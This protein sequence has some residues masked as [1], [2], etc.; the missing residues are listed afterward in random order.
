MARPDSS[1]STT[2]STA[3][4]AH[5]ALASS[6][7]A[8]ENTHGTRAAAGTIRR[9]SG[10][11]GRDQQP[12]GE[13]LVPPA[14]PAPRRARSAPG[15][16]RDRRHG[17]P[18]LGQP[19]RDALAGQR[20]DVAG[21]V[22]DEQH[23]PGDPAPGP[24][25][26]RPGAAHRVA[27]PARAARR[28]RGSPPSCSSN[29]RALPV[30]TATPTRSS[31]DRRHVR[32]AGRRPVDLD[33]VRPRRDA[34]VAAQAVAARPCAGDLQAEQ[35][36]ER[37]CRPSAATSQRAGSPSTSTWSPRSRD[38]RPP[39]GPTATPR[40]RRR[41]D[42]AACSV[43]RRTPRP[44]PSP[45][46]CLAPRPPRRGSGSRAAAAR[47]VAR[48]ARRAPATALGISPSPHALS[49]GRRAARTTTSSP[50]R[51]A[52]IAVGQ[53]DR[54]AP[55][56]DRSRTRAPRLSRQRPARR[57]HPDPHRQQR[58]VERP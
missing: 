35:P 32:L 40:R 16:R 56:D 37:E 55:G 45:E 22:A 41:R 13:Q 3:A 29:G 50:A 48:P 24:L 18:G 26:Q 2:D 54:A 11:P 34:R 57:P 36:A 17:G 51:A 1:R 30:S 33:E 5:A 25:A 9:R 12:V 42:S 43:V 14:Q 23:P 44:G 47:R 39:A 7:T 27:L 20:V 58:G 6:S 49:T 4:V 19:E 21:R 46:R 10:G 53:P 52:W 15:V 38:R 28:A 8:A 31:A